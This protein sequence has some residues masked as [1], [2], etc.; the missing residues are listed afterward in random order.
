MSQFLVHFH[1]KFGTLLH[2]QDIQEWKNIT[3]LNFHCELDGRLKA[4]E[5]LKKL[6][7]SAM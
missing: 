2:D 4:V 5:V 7:Q 3:L 1:G 6:L